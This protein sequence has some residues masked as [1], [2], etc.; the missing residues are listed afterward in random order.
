M[1]L[2][3]D[4]LKQIYKRFLFTSLG[5]TIIISVYSTVDTVAVGQ[6]YGP[7]GTAF[8]SCLN[9]LWSI[10]ISLGI[11][12][13][14]GGSVWMSNCRG[15]G[16]RKDGDQ[17]FTLALI[18]VSTLAATISV[19]MNLFPEEL[20]RFFGADDE[21]LPYAMEYGIWIIRF[22]PMFFFGSFLSSFIR[23]D[24]SPTYC[25]FAVLTGGILNIIGDIVLVFVFDMGAAGAGIATAA[26]QAVNVLIYT[27]R[28][29]TKRNTLRLAKIKN[30]PQKL[31]HIIS[32][33]FAPFIVDLS[34]GILVILFNN[35]IMRHAGSDELAVFGTIANIAILFQALFYGVGQAQ[36][37]I[38]SVNFG[39]KR[40]DRVRQLFR[41]ST[42]TALGMSLLFF[43]VCQ[44]F[45][46]FMLKV[47]MDVTP[48]V[49]AIGPGIIRIYAVSFL[50]MGMNIL[51]TY[52]LQ[53]VL[54]STQSV[55]ISFCRGVLFCVGLVVLL[56]A[57]FSFDAIWWTMPLT[58]LFTLAVA[59]FFLK[60]QQRQA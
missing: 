59:L 5:S 18:I 46:G 8:I 7:I 45:P 55:V 40:L 49:M 11:L 26:G 43:G 36:Q 52:Y 41:Y 48:E 57:V 47:F 16:C 27:C 54:C 32:A 23:N 24:N 50:F 53:S 10:M 3:N 17:Y 12:C 34:F 42:R 22:A 31:W 30:V 14:I 4:D 21:I 6:Y 38:T 13:G 37:P 33:G 29:F 44:L 35:Q 51:S 39:A 28:F 58:E 1:D 2:Q 20:I 60:R 19:L 25:T 15:Q 9:P 56:P